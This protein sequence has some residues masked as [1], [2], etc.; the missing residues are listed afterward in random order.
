ML[1]DMVR[2]DR[3]TT[4]MLESEL[5]EAVSDGTF[6]I[7]GEA[8][9]AEG[10]KYDFRLGPRVLKASFE[11]P[12]DVT[13]LTGLDKNK[14]AVEP[15]EVVFVLTKEKLNL[16]S[17]IIV[18][19]TPKRKLSHEGIHVLGGLCVDPLYKG[20]LLIGL[21]NF[22]SEPFRIVPGKKLI[23]GIFHRLGKAEMASFEA[24]K[25]EIEDFPDELVRLIKVYQ[26]IGTKELLTQI[27]DVKNELAIIKSQV[28]DDTKWKGDFQG[29]LD[30]HNKQIENLIRGLE[31]E[32]EVREAKLSDLD[33][34][35]QKHGLSFSNF[36]GGIATVRTILILLLGTAFGIALKFYFDS[37]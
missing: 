6:I 11:G 12:V 7:D 29:F 25:I 10:I 20:H 31:T 3:M 8:S 36:M 13:T 18:L 4:I 16:P 37:P 1:Q 33:A 9:C 24:P 19:L 21:H 22:S 30:A 17:N 26:P 28:A 35:I 27:K 15:G 23:A 5:R 32:K 2:G 34:K 14:A